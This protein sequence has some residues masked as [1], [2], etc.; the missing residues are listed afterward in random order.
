PPPDGAR[1]GQ[2]RG[3]FMTA[4]IIRRALWGVV[5]LFLVAALTFVFFYVFPSADPAVLR[6]GRS[7]SP[8]S[9]AFIRH[10]LGLDKPVYTQFYDY[11]KA[12][13]LHFN[14]G[15]SYYSNASVLSLI[16]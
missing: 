7:P 12:I 15:Y 3:T 13:V 9:I 5:L 1:G 4:Y 6:A 16:T 10:E 14:F 11:M 2:D 8:Q